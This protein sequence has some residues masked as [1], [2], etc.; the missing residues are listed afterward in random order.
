MSLDRISFALV[1]FWLAGMVL[2]S[3]EVVLVN[4]NQIDSF[5]VGKDGCKNDNNICSTSAICRM[6]DGFCQC[7]SNTPTYR[8]FILNTNGLKGLVYG[9]VSNSLI[10]LSSNNE[11]NNCS[12]T[13]SNVIPFSHNDSPVKFSYNGSN[14]ELKTCR[15]VKAWTKTPNTAIETEMK[16]MNDSYV[17]LS[18][19][20][21]SLYFKVSKL[22]IYSPNLGALT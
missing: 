15:L 21:N 17:G 9:C 22:K 10:G 3:S 11:R 18:V 6:S 8:K 1:C 19:S 2:S 4:R 5:R 16:W 14:V 7:K 12:F 13:A 20:D